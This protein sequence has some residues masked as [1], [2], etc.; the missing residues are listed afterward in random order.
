MQ[1]LREYVAQLALADIVPRPDNEDWGALINRISVPG[2]IA[3]VQEETYYYFL[4]V[5]PPQ[6][7]SGNLFAFAE[8]TEEL[9]IFWRRQ[10]RFFCRQLTFA[11]TQEFCRLAGI[12][13]P[14]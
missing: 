2:T 10:G 5:L 13:L 4:E 9:R 1:T 14:S 11:E 7:Q 12:P 3:E 6:Y 8:G